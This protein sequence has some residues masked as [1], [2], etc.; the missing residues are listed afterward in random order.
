M[1]KEVVFTAFGFALILIVL[2]AIAFHF[3]KKLNVIAESID[4]GKNKQIVNSGVKVHQ[5]ANRP[6]IGF[7]QRPKL[8]PTI[9]CD[10]IDS[11]KQN[12]IL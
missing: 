11:N 8:D 1:K 2:L 3:N 7:I 4:S 6:P 5:A 12:N 10:N 9:K